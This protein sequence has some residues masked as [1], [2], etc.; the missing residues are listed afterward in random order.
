MS[1]SPVAAT[2]K[3]QVRGGAG[4]RELVRIHPAVS[5]PG[6]WTD[7]TAPGPRGAGPAPWVDQCVRT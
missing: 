2:L 5:S 4:P 3:S 6:S 1:R 7:A